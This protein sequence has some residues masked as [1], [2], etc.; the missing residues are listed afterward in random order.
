MHSLLEMLHHCQES[1][2][3]I[4]NSLERLDFIP[5]FMTPSHLILIKRLDNSI[6]LS[7]TLQSLQ[8]IVLA[9]EFSWEKIKVQAIIWNVIQN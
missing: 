7:T 3:N 6:L 1:N 4:R 8:I 5:S 9:E 2:N